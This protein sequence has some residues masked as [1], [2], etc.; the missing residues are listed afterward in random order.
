MAALPLTYTDCVCLLDCDPYASETTSDL[1]N[2]SQD[3]L[4]VLVQLPDS[5]PDDPGRGVGISQYLNCKETDFRSL[6]GIVDSQLEQ[7]PRITSSKTTLQTLPDG[8]FVVSI[9]VKVA[10][11]VVPLAYGVTPDGVSPL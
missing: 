10:N 1:Q 3:V 9:E 4:H 5:N 2:L 7:D 11:S 8:G 6:S